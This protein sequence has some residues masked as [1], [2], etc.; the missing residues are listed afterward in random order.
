MII[1]SIPCRFVTPQGL[2]YVPHIYL[3]LYSV[4]VYMSRILLMCTTRP[5]CCSYQ[6]F[7]LSRYLLAALDLLTCH[8]LPAYSGHTSHTCAA[9]STHTYLHCF[10]HAWVI[11]TAMTPI[12]FAAYLIWHCALVSPFPTFL[13]VFSACYDLYFTWLLVIRSYL[14]I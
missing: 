3:Y 13:H 6:T 12:F 14:Y 2:S 4:T 11:S 7:P 1:K 9:P 8:G 10:W 5:P